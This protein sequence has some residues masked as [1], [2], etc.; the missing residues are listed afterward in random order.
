VI[1]L[2]P[3]TRAKTCDDIKPTA[4]LLQGVRILLA[5]HRPS[6]RSAIGDGNAYGQPGPAQ[7]EHEK[8]PAA[9]SRM[10]DRIGR[11]LSR[12]QS[13]VVT[14]RAVGQ[15]LGDEPP[16]LADLVF[17]TLE[18]PAP[19]HRAPRLADLYQPSRA[20]GRADGTRVVARRSAVALAMVL[21]AMR[22]LAVSQDLFIA[23]KLRWGTA[24][25]YSLVSR[26]AE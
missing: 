20:A 12:A 19:P 8:T 10:T 2:S 4:D 22:R 9:A 5:V 15:K 26:Y 25:R 17:A 6:R 1:S 13:N 21:R 11:Q 23:R 3:V 16:N 24:D 7:L 18:D 14:L